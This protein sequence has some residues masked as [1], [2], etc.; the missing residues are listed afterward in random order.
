M[1][2]R[3]L[4]LPTP[5]PRRTYKPQPP[6]RYLPLTLL[7]RRRNPPTHPLTHPPTHPPHPH[8]L[9][10][11]C[12][13][14]TSPSLYASTGSGC[15]SFRLL[16]L[17]DSYK[18]ALMRGNVSS[19]LLLATSAAVGFVQPNEVSRSR[20]V[21]EWV[22]RRALRTCTHSRWVGGG[23]DVYM[24]TTPPLIQPPTH[25]TLHTQVTQIHLALTDTSGEVRSFFSSSSYPPTH[26][27]IQ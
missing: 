21:G 11:L 15:V 4:L 20:W 27:R 26:P 18:F 10:Y 12:E 16:N 17:R 2:L 25:Y 19:P 22:G 14:T 1:R 9:K 7:K 8:Q 13:G 23:I 3:I 6:S 5:L 24:H